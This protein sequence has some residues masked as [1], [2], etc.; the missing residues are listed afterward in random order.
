MSR[1]NPYTDVD[2]W[3]EFKYDVTHPGQFLGAAYDGLR[4][5]N[6]VDPMMR[7]LGI[8]MVGLGVAQIVT[9]AF[10]IVAG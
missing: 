8:L 10:L 1:T 6:N 5:R 3:K 2:S 4:G 7:V 9:G